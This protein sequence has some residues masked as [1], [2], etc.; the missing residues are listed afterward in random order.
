MIWKIAL[1]RAFAIPIPIR[2]IV[3]QYFF[4]SSKNA[5]RRYGHIAGELEQIFRILDLFRMFLYF[6]Q[7]RNLQSA[8]S[9]HCEV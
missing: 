1:F 6:N 9:W 5:C 2:I 3:L 7:F 4:A 8:A